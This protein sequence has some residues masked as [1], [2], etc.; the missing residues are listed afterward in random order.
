MLAYVGSE[1]RG[2]VATAAMLLAVPWILA[3]SP[4][5]SLA[6][7]FPIAYFSWS[8]WNENLRAALLSALVAGILLVGLNYVA[9]AT[10]GPR[11]RPVASTIDP[12]LAETSWREFTSE[13]SGGGLSAW[14]VRIPTWS[15]LGMV[16]GLALV[17]AKLPSA[18]AARGAGDIVKTYRVIAWTIAVV[19]TLLP[20]AAQFYGD[21]TAGWL[22]VDFRAYYCAASA[23]RH[24]FNPYFA[25][26]LHACES[27]TAPPTM[28]ARKCHGPGAVSTLRSRDALSADTTA[29]CRGGHRMV[30]ISVRLPSRGGTCAGSRNP[31]VVSNRLGGSGAIARSVVVLER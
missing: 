31:S 7:I 23:A 22:N 1:Y 11:H 4:I 25:E 24:H 9:R 30:G 14:L 13:D 21:R 17:T 6:P 20:L 15:G 8:T 28:G 27:T 26:P 2:L 18:R 12:S 10:P 16:L 3:W 19:C 29:V 5:L